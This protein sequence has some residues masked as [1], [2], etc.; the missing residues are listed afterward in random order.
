MA[1]K[2]DML[3]YTAKQQWGNTYALLAAQAHTYTHILIHTHCFQMALKEAMLEYPAKQQWGDRYALL[4]A[5]VP[6]KT[7]DQVLIISVYVYLY[8][9]CVYTVAVRHVTRY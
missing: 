5:R 3:K 7:P 9:K 4:A 8:A 6:G 2:E 1:L